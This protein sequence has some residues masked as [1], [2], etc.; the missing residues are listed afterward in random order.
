[1]PEP[2]GL[3]NF[4]LVTAN[5]GQLDRSTSRTSEPS[6]NETPAVGSHSVEPRLPVRIGPQHAFAGLRPCVP[7][8]VEAKPFGAERGIEGEADPT[9]LMRLTVPG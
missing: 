9:R 1:M 2:E 6:S 4:H 5:A 8:A 7:R 3:G